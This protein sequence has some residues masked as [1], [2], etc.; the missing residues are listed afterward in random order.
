MCCMAVLTNAACSGEWIHWWRDGSIYPPAQGGWHRKLLEKLSNIN[1]GRWDAIASKII[2]R[3]WSCSCRSLSFRDFNQKGKLIAEQPLSLRSPE[4]PNLQLLPFAKVA[5]SKILSRRER[6]RD[7]SSLDDAISLL[8][9][10]KK[11]IVLSGAGISTSCGIPDFRSSTGLYAQLQEEGKYELD[12]PQQ[13]F[14]IRF[15]R[16]KPEVF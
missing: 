15:F 11:I 14:D 1:W 2:I 4:T 3:L 12:D 5:L 6:L 13:M 7:L 10:S 8:A 16:E 9:K